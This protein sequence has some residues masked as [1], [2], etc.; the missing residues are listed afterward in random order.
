M[1]SKL[2]N[3]IEYITKKLLGILLVKNSKDFIII[4]YDKENNTYLNSLSDKYGSDKGSLETKSELPWK[5]HSYL[6]L[7]S[8]LY[9]GKENHVHNVFECG[10]G[11]NNP[12]LPSSM[13]E[14]GKPGASLR[15]WRDYFNNAQIYGA[16]IDKSILFKEERINTFYVDQLNEASIKNMVKEMKIEKE[17]FDLIID[18]GLHTFDAGR[19]LLEVMIPYLKDGGNYI[20]EDVGRVSLRH[21]RTYFEGNK[22]YTINYINLFRS[23]EFLKD[24]RI[25]LIQKNS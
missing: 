7:I 15:M 22:L 3:L 10:I 5:P 8:F 13:T 11:T 21:F 1:R 19:S 25:I 14:K 18:D 4:D 16:D 20:I 2:S 23:Y 9:K 12:L 17:F 6:D 24:N